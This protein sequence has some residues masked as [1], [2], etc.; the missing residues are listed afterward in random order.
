MVG[1]ITH[2]SDYA[3]A[4]VGP[5]VATGGIGI[6]LELVRVVD[7]LAQQVAHGEE[8]NYV[9]GISE[10]DRPVAL[11]TLFS[12]KETI[13]KAFFPRVGSYFGFE[14]AR[15]DPPFQ[16]ERLEARLVEPLD[17][18]WPTDRTFQVEVSQYGELVLT[19]LV[20]P[21]DA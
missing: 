9:A 19:A 14:A 10:E 15:V 6:D 5:R 7:G 8:V 3:L 1:S 2:A 12:A 18:F 17:P 13:F 21:A 11:M 16:S 4:L 20:L